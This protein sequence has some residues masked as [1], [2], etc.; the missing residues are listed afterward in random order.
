MGLQDGLDAVPVGVRGGYNR[1]SQRR[2]RSAAPSLI[3]HGDADAVVPMVEGETMQAAL[4][5]AGVPA[6]FSRIEGAGP[7]AR[8]REAV[9]PRRG[10]R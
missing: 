10:R 1:A 3:V 2:P 4:A 5:K 7:L 6:S 8:G 9:H